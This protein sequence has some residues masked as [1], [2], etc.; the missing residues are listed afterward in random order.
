[1][2]TR[3]I[4]I[5]DDSGL[6]N[7]LEV[8]GGTF[9]EAAYHIN[10]FLKEPERLDMELLDLSEQEKLILERQT[11]CNE[12]RIKMGQVGEL[13]LN[14]VA[15]NRNPRRFKTEWSDLNSQLFKLERANKKD[16]R[17][18]GQVWK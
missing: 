17:Q 1:M 3:L 6:R 5:K 13:R 14:A 11:Q 2:E 9:F 4:P 16:L 10:G 8:P 15:H 7:Y 18:L 12:L